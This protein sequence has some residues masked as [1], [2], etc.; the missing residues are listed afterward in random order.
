MSTEIFNVPP[1]G[2]TTC[3]GTGTAGFGGDGGP[4]IAAQLNAPDGMAVDAGSLYVADCFNNR[5]R[6]VDLGTGIITTFAG[7]GT[8]GFGGDGGPAIAASLS[9][10]EGLVIWAGS[11]YITDQGN[12]RVRRVDL[13]TGIITTFAG[14][15]TVGFGGD[16]G[17]AIAAQLNTPRGMAVDEEGNVYFA[18]WH[19]NRVRKVKPVAPPAVYTLAQVDGAIPLP[20]SAGVT[21]SS[22][23]TVS[24]DRVVPAGKPV[25]VTFPTGLSLPADGQ[26]RYICPAD[27]TNIPLFT[28][29]TGAALSS[30]TFPAQEITGSTACFY[31]M[32]IQA[33]G[34]VTGPLYAT[35][36]IAG[37]TGVLAYK[38]SPV[39]VTVTQTPP[40]PLVLSPGDYGSLGFT[41]SADTVSPAGEPVT[42]TFPAGVSMQPEGAVVYICS[43][44]STPVYTNTTGTY[45]PVVT[46]PAQEITGS[47]ACFYSVNVQAT[48]NPT[49]PAQG[50]ISV[51]GTTHPINI[52]TS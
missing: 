11:L 39:T 50:N 12:N 24:A 2:I 15:G 51:A 5:V 28:N 48:G 17:P 16:G 13:A 37:A 49:G 47:T 26:V 7:T 20:L 6:K 22:A 34:A 46:F 36:A 45:Q 21:V 40:D 19:N 3:V 25:T 52:T 8:A 42:V 43:G 27:G 10:P 44:V 31:S 18:C 14:T 30:V 32:N 35:V 1:G 23:F 4:A 9:A 33:S 41:V 29:T 38:V